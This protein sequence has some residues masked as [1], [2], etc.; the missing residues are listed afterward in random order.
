MSSLSHNAALCNL[1][2]FWSIVTAPDNDD[3]NRL[4]RARVIRGRA[5]RKKKLCTYFP[6]HGSPRTYTTS[7]IFRKREESTSCQLVKSFP[8]RLPL[9]VLLG[10]WQVTRVPIESPA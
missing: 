5:R 2:S 1:R 9:K 3:N 7:Q 4:A 6:F 10:Y 8:P